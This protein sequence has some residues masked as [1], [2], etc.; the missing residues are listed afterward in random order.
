VQ[1]TLLPALPVDGG[2]AGASE[3]RSAQVP[4]TIQSEPGRDP[5]FSFFTDAMPAKVWHALTDPSANAH[6]PRRHGV[7]VGLGRSDLEG[8][9]YLGHR[10]AYEE[11]PV[12]PLMRVLASVQFSLNDCAP[13]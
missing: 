2:F 4:T 13:A 7:A 1:N 12:R 11:S 6:V 9:V 8:Y 5:V 10:G 3:E